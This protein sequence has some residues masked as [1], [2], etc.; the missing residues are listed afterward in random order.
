MTLPRSDD[1][2]EYLFVFSKP[3]IDACSEKLIEIKTLEGN[4]SNRVNFENILKNLNFK[5][6]I[7]NGHGSKTCICGHNDGELVKLGENEVLLKGR[8]TYARSCWAVDGLGRE[9]MKDDSKGC[10]IGY[11]IPFMFLID[12]TWITNPFKDKI[13]EI[14]FKT[15]NKVPL[16]V[17]KGNSTNDAHENAKKS[18]LKA[19]KKRLRFGDKDSGAIAEILWNNYLG[20]EIVGNKLA[21]L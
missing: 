17:I 9:S 7:F 10:F 20:Q 19:I 16:S 11:K 13:A 1:V 12:K 8:I 21:K 2:T 5:M 3:I 6:V 15:S 18:M 14:F 4:K